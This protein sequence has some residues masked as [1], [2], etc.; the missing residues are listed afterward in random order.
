VELQEQELM[1]WNFGAIEKVADVDDDIH[2]EVVVT[3]SAH[4]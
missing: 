3:R 2:C 4:N 1:W